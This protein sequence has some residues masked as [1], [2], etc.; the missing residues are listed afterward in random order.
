MYDICLD[1]RIECRYEPS[2]HACVNI[3]FRPTSLPKN[4]S[5]FVFQSGNLII[6]GAKNIEN[7]LES[8][9]YINHLLGS[10]KKLIQKSKISEVLFDNMNEE[11]KELLK[12][13]SKDDL[14]AI[15]LESIIW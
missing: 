14:A 11:I 13:D 9:N 12:Y 1:S 6:T 5:I 7:I 2:I 15:A 10:N 8:Y 4:V 3:K